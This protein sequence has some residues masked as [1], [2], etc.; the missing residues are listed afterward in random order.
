VKDDTDPKK[1]HI[2]CAKCNVD[3]TI[4]KVTLAYMGSTFPVDLYKCPKCG[5]V[6]IPEDLAMGKMEKAEKALEDK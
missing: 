5:L 2:I 1:F 4:G 6:Y 3:L